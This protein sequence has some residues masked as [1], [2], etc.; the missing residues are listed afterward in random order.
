MDKKQSV[1]IFV[2]GG[3][4]TD[5]T[6]FLDMVE[7]NRVSLALGRFM[8]EEDLIIDVAIVEPLIRTLDALVTMIS[9]EEPIG[10]CFLVDSTD[11]RSIYEGVATLKYLTLL[12]PV[13]HIIVA[14]KQD[15]RDALTLD[16]IRRMMELTD[17]TI[18]LPCV[19]R[20]RNS[21]VNMF[22][23]LLQMIQPN[24]KI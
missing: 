5:K 6:L 7:T 9:E 15:H 20:E 11:S 19:A 2:I 8:I 3:R 1:T 16:A 24:L 14:N 23:T 17:K 22:S 12:D 10:V 21:V 4:G 18:L 13:L